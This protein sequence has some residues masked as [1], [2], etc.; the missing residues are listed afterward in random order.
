MHARPRFPTLAAV[1]LLTVLAESPALAA[2]SDVDKATAR[3]LTTQGYDALKAKDWAAA[4]DRFSRAERLFQAAGDAVP[5][6]ISVGVARAHAMLG[7]LV[8]AQEHYSRVTHEAVPPNASAAY[9]SAV[10]DAQRELP[11]LSARVPS[12]VINVNGTDTA[13]VTF[14]DIEV[15]SAAYGVKRPADPGKH[16]VKASA[17]GFTPVELSVTLTE[18]KV[19]TVTLELRPGPGGPPPVTVTAPVPGGPLVPIAPPDAPPPA[20]EDKSA[21]LRRTIGFVGIGVGGAGLVVGAITGGLALAK[22][23][24]LTS[25]C[26]GGHCPPGSQSV[27]QSKIDSFNTMAAVSTAGFVVGGVLAATGVILVATSPKPKTTGG[28]TPFIG[29][30]NAGVLGRF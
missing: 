10:E 3:E 16:L 28:I 7:K 17:V 27:N 12:V 11:A 21:A 26:P 15:S 20:P 24:D 22:H 2:I 1:L 13:K 23:G 8:S 19:E 25:T 5:P 29:L 18:G 30:G 14:D 4:A 6:T 9:L